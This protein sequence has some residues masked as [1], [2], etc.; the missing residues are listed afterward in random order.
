MIVKIEK[1]GA[2]WCAPCKLVDKALEQVPDNIEVIKID[3]EENEELA[4]DKKIRNIPVLIF[5]DENN[6]EINRLV[7]AISIDKINSVI[8]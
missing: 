2:S 4:L 8:K 5:Y 1:Y 6:N 7:G 3:I